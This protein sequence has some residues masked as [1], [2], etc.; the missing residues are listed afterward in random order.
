V[1]EDEIAGSRRDL[2]EWLGRPVSAFAYPFGHRWIDYD[3]LGRRLTQ[4]AGFDHAVSVSQQP[5]TMRGGRYELPR[6]PAHDWDG[7]ELSR[8]LD[9]LL[10]D[11]TTSR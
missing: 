7:D 11:S 4:T 10:G 8:R 3:T 5:V 2:E 9:Y 6:D 1:Q